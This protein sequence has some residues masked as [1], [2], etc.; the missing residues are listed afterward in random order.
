VEWLPVTEAASA[1]SS[2]FGAGLYDAKTNILQLSLMTTNL[3]RGKAILNSICTEYNLIDIEERSKLS[4]RTVRFIDER[5]TMISGELRSVEGS[6]ESYQS[7]RNLVDIKSQAV[8]S[9]ENQ[10]VAATAIRELN[11]QQGIVTMISSYFSKPSTAG[12]LV[13]SSMGLNDETLASLIAQYNQL[14]LKRER[15]A[16]SMGLNSLALQDM[17]GQIESLKSSILESLR[18]VSANLR[19]QESRLQG[20]NTQNRQFLASVPHNERVMQEIKR[21]QSITEGLYL[22]LLQKREEAAISSTGASISNYKQIDSAKGY[23]P[24]EPNNRNIYLY[25]A[26]LGLFIP[27][28]FVYLRDLLNDKIVS[29]D[30]IG[31]I[32]AAPVIS[33]VVHVAKMDDRILTGGTRSLLSEQFRSLRTNLAYL[34]KAKQVILITSTSGSEG[35][36]FVS[37]NLAIV[38]ATPGKKVALVEFDIRKPSVSATLG[39]DGSEGVTGFLSGEVAHL[40]DI[41]EVVPGSPNLHLY[42]A[43]LAPLNPGDLFLSERLGEL[44]QKLREAYDYIVVDTAPVGL[45]SDA[46]LLAGLSDI[47]L[48]VVR[49]RSTRKKQLR[50]LQDITETGKLHHLGLV[51]NDVKTGSRYGYEGYGYETKNGYYASQSTRKK[52]KRKMEI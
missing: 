50:I 26:L 16:P 36:S 10:N 13:P 44:F 45:V 22:Y 6:Q 41:C 52:T 23:G 31:K 5:L 19:L 12:K 30:D 18:N 9:F 42:S 32:V 3:E 4:E 27:I 1:L 38:L 34:N 49:Q 48:Y 11:I 15:E 40:P 47:T 46:L 8:Q 25:T 24:V 14:Q 21:K 39:L 37:I 28:G 43:G 29:R 2:Q 51:L 33:D 7:S 17:D 35:K 20:H